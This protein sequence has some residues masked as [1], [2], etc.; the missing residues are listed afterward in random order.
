MKRSALISFIRELGLETHPF[1]HI[2]PPGNPAKK[3][4]NSSKLPIEMPKQIC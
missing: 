2:L 4:L 3:G 1:Q